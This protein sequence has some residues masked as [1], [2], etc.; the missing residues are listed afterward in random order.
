MIKMKK[1]RFV[2]LIAGVVIATLVVSGAGLYLFA[3]ANDMALVSKSKYETAVETGNKYAK[4]DQLQKLT[5]EQFLWDV[6]EEAQMDAIYKAAVDALGDKYSYYMNEEEYKEWS[7]MITGTFTGVGVVFTQDE[8]GSYVV[9]RVIEDGP[10]DLAGIKAGDILLKVDGKFYEDSNEMAMAIRGESGT[11]VKVTY[12]HGKET[13]TAEMVRAEV[14]EPSVYATKFKEGKKVYGYLQITAF[15]AET[16]KQFEK[17][18]KALENDQVAGVIIDLRNNPGGMV[19][20]CVEIADMLLPEAVITYTEDR[21]G[22]QETYNSDEHCTKLNYVVVV[23]EHSASASEIIAAAV[24]DNKGGPLVGT[25]T[26]GKGIIQGSMDFEDGSAM[27]LTIMQYFSPNGTKIHQ[28]GV[29][30]NYVEK[31]DENAK[32]DTQLEK[33]LDLLEEM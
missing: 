8:E 19:D 21:K 1:N 3:S 5:S 30:P 22:N 28:T 23:N 10:A 9:N 12:Q 6:N 18:L 11:T 4:L 7:D 31:L 32:T 17:E 16:A 26:F 14:T 15:E 33:A 24:K 25:K 2:L 27:T 20:Q 13:K 29:K